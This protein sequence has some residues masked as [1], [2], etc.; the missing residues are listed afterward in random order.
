M[1]GCKRELYTYRVR[2]NIKEHRP[3]RNCEDAV[4]VAA[5]SVCQYVCARMLLEAKKLVEIYYGTPHMHWG[6]E[7][8]SIW[9]CPARHELQQEAC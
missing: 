7:H 1:D 6:L 3:W 2:N 8:V 5:C 9:G 4:A